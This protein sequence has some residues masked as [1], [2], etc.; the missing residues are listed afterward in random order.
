MR[1][2]HLVA[3][4]PKRCGLYETTHDT[5]SGLRRLGIDSRLVDPDP[6]NNKV[7]FNAEEDRGVPVG[8]LDWAHS[9]ADVI[10]SHSGFGDHFRDPSYKILYVAHG[11]PYVS[12]LTERNG[13]LPLQ[14]WHY[15][16][17]FDPRFKAIVS[18]WPEHQP[19]L[20]VLFPDKDVYTVQ[21]SVD[22]EAWKPAPSDYDFGGKGGEVNVVI[23]DNWRDDIDPYVAL[24]A[25]A[26]WSK[27]KPW[28]RLHIY[29]LS[30]NQPGAWALVRCIQDLGTLGEVVPWCEDLATVYNRADFV[31]TPHVIDVRTVREAMACGCPVVRVRE[32]LQFEEPSI[33]RAAVRAEAVR[34][35][36]STKTALQFKRILESL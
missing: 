16:K 33:D 8:S 28:A 25:F 7:G 24:N 10:V 21:S 22:L 36:D 15:Q 32:S 23:A 6:D 2:A 30:K 12:Y 29:G 17:N 26:R 19:Y 3:I 5:I 35:F 14:S 4:T 1:V 13:G 27:D 31:L 34:R 9:E 20:E 11:R 18:Y